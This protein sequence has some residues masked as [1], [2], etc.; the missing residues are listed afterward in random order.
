[1]IFG[2]KATVEIVTERQVYVAGE[3]LNARVRI[4]GQGD[5][6][7]E[8]ARVELQRHQKFAYER[9]KRN[10]D[11][12][13]YWSSTSETAH[14]TLATERILG[15]G[16]LANGQFF[17]QF[18]SFRLL[19]SLEPSGRA[20]LLSTSWSVELI[21]NRRRAIDITGAAK[22]TILAPAAQNSA[23]IATRP[24]SRSATVC[25][26]LPQIVARDLQVG[27]TVTGTLVVFARQPAEAR[28]V[29]IELVRIEKTDPPHRSDPTRGEHSSTVVV[30]QQIAAGGALPVGVPWGFPFAITLPPD[31]HPTSFT[32]R[33][34]VR[35][36]LRGVVDRSF[37]EDFTGE[38]EVNIANAPT[39]A[40]PP[41][42]PGHTAQANGTVD[43]DITTLD[44]LGDEEPQAEPA[45]TAAANVATPRTAAEPRA[46]VLDAGPEGPFAS[47]IFPLD[48]PLIS[49][50]RREENLLSIA[51]LAVSRFHA[52]IRREGGVFLLR[53]LGSTTGTYV[54][55]APLTGDHPLQA[56]EVVGIG[57]AI[58]FIV[59]D[60]AE[61]S[62]EDRSLS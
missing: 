38:I 25:A 56:G 1:M 45:Q 59:R 39:F 12:R 54:N 30:K 26:V 43:F 61:I 7:I 36:L 21:L 53:D 4:W 2:K 23:R 17:E 52:E 33:G 19:D 15:P 20:S 48:R 32:A 37:A 44:Q 41:P 35:W 3:V 29:R 60:A 47:R 13:Y 34:D 8:E 28:S 22:F 6:A 57:P 11:G 50:G 14:S 27:A 51:D 31:L 40:P 10:D 49:I 42:P 9:R 24:R 58:T 18:V 46:L 55:G 16:Q 5:L 62:Q